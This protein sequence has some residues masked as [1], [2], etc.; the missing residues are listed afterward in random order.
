MRGMELT[1]YTM[2]RLRENVYYYQGSAPRALGRGTVKL[3]LVFTSEKTWTTTRVLQL[4][5]Q[6]GCQHVFTFTGTFLR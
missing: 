3:T 5:N 4:T 1:P 2:R 6:P